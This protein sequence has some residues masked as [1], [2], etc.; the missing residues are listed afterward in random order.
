M[1]HVL[2]K[3]AVYYDIHF[4]VSLFIIINF[5][6][7]FFDTSATRAH[8]EDG[9]VIMNN[10]F[11]KLRGQQSIAIN[12]LNNKPEFLLQEWHGGGAKIGEGNANDQGQRDE[13]LHNK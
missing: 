12:D 10:L 7:G 1:Y 3:F 5:V 6:N 11:T 9:R 2:I 4:L 8:V 13:Y